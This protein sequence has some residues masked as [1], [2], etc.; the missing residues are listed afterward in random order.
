MLET[1]YF[2]KTAGFLTIKFAVLGHSHLEVAA[3]G[4]LGIPDEAFLQVSG[5]Q[6]LGF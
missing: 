2:P 1:K 3:A 6:H 5:L 4:L